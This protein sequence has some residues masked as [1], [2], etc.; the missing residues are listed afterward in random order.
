MQKSIYSKQASLR[1][2]QYFEYLTEHTK[3][4]YNRRVDYFKSDEAGR[5]KST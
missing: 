4:T 5:L 1:N 3:P 2:S